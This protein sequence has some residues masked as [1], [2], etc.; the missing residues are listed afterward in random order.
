MGRLTVL[1]ARAATEPGLYGDGG[2]L[3]LAVAPG[4]S[5][6]WI[7]RLTVRGKRTDIGLGGFPLVPLAEA[8]E[9]AIDNRRVARAGG[10]P[11]A[12]KRRALVP[13]F[14]AALEET[15]R[16]M[17]G[18]WR[19]GSPTEAIWRRTLE[20][21]AAT[22]MDKRVNNIT[23][24]DVLR[25]LTP[26]WTKKPETAKRTRQFTRSVLS[27]AQAHGY[28][29]HNVAGEAIAGALPTATATRQHHRALPWADVPEALRV[30]AASVSGPAVRLC[31]NLVV[32]TAVRNGEARGSR[33]SEFDLEARTWTIP[34]ERTKVGTEHRVPL[35]DA[36]VAVLDAARVLDDGSGLV[37]PSPMKRGRP[38]SDMALMKLLRHAGLSDRC[39]VHGFRSSFRD[40]C[41][42]T[43]KPREL[44][45]AALAHSVNG[46]EGAYFRS[47][48]FDR[49]RRLMDQWAGHATATPAGKV[50]ALHG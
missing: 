42:D 46:V 17:R 1:K 22:F 4:G 30:V 18:R 13:T 16:A 12:E 29:E 27:W 9:K 44:A 48:L 47:D 38:L 6:S 24:E 3:F 49:R 11:L 20:R 50:V 34:A 32:L 31:F 43:G 10:D 45:E 14:K 5:K 7:Q 39:V 8:R 28:V 26:V 21:N 19:K 40:W 37:F 15:I 41:A 2:T 35:S 23:R 33:W 36:S 25:V